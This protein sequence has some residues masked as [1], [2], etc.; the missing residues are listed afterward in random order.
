MATL[1]TIEHLLD[2]IDRLADE[3]RTEEI[4]EVVA[5][6]RGEIVGDDALVTTTQAAK[7]LGIG[8]INTIKSMVRHGEITTIRK[9]GN[10]TMIPLGEIKRLQHTDLVRDLRAIA[11]AMT[12]GALP[13]AEN[14][15]TPMSPEQMDILEAGRPG[16]LPWKK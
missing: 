8:S 16:T 14:E 5:R 9:V 3:D 6:A 13:D 12:L 15:G 11:G 4:K 7:L 1:A 10:R 2:E